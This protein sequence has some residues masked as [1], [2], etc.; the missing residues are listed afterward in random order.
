MVEECSF[1]K[2]ME[3]PPIAAYQLHGAVAYMCSL[4]VVTIV[5]LLRL[6]FPGILGT[7][8]YLI[9]YPVIVV[10]AAFCGSGPGIVAVVASW[11]CAALPVESSAGFLNL[12]RIEVG[13]LLIF[14]SVV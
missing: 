13:R 5:A 10:V 2:I 4:L 6:L 1:I 11:L 7:T 3:D 8:P 14:L 12:N 9:F